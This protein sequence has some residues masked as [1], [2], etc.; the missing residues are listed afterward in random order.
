MT[1]ID[2]AESKMMDSARRSGLLENQPSQSSE[3]RRPDSGVN[4]HSSDW[5]SGGS[6]YDNEAR[7]RSLRFRELILLGTASRSDSLMLFAEAITATVIG[8]DGMHITFGDYQFATYF[9]RLQISKP[10]T[11]PWTCEVC[12]EKT[13]ETAER[14]TRIMKGDLKT[15]YL[16][17]TV[18]LNPFDGLYLAPP[19]VENVYHSLDDLKEMRD[20]QSAAVAAA[21]G[22][23]STSEQTERVAKDVHQR[24]ARL[25]VEKKTVKKILQSIH[26]RRRRHVEEQMDDLRTERSYEDKYVILL[27]GRK[28][29]RALQDKRAAFNGW[30][31]KTDIAPWTIMSELSKMEDRLAHGIVETVDV[32]CGVCGHDGNVAIPFA[33][34]DFFPE[35]D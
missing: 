11:V 13:P 22:S 20:I 3:D 31:E 2:A 23:L 16:D 8:H 12:A 29:G 21:D 32:H 33:P 26:D 25:F 6:F 1:D 18:D 34:T 4:E 15:I 5:P 30:L 9:H 10:I 17:P 19:T 27:D 7:M 28:Y 35:V 14:T 24:L